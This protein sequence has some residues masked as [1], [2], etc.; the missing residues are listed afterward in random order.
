[1]SA[2]TT[3]HVT[4]ATPT[5]TEASPSVPKRQRAGSIINDFCLTTSIQGFPGIARSES[6]HNRLFWTVALISFTGIML[7]FIVDAI[8]VYFNYPTQTSVTIVTEWPQAFPAVSICNY[9]MLRYDRFIGPFL[10]YTN[11][12][13]ITNTTDTT[14]FTGT[15]SY[16]I[17]DFLIDVVNK[18]EPF[19]DY[20]FPLSGMMMSCSY[21]GVACT[22]ANFTS[23]ISPTYGMC[24]TFNAKLKNID[25]GGI[26]YN[27]D[28][29]ANGL[30]QLALYTHEQQYVP[31]MTQGTGIVALVHDNS[32][33][34][35]VE[36]EAVF[37]S[38]GRHHRLGFKK[39]KSLF[40][41]SPYTTCT[42]TISPG[43]QIVYDAYNATD[44]AYSQYYCFNA[45]IQ[46]YIYSHCGCGGPSLWNVP[47]VIIHGT[48]QRINISLC[49]TSNSCPKQYITFILNTA[50]TL[51]AYC[52]QC[53]EECTYTEF[54]MKLSSLLAP[55]VTA[56][57][58]IK[59][60]VESSNITLSNDWSTSWISEIQ[61][62]YVSLEVAYETVRT[63]VY[64]QQARLSPVDVLSNV[65]GQTGLWIGISFLSVIEIA[66]MAYRL[67]RCLWHNLRT[68]VNNR[69]KTQEAIQ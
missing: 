9:G 6:I 66:E 23:F 47:A 38:P 59:Q 43:L 68:I 33:V 61:S 8:S 35:N 52:S 1:M 12:L 51:N 56:L 55:P 36:M 37:L 50:S 62:N 48:D 45:C 13:N 11:A 57:T 64:S 42:E 41:A 65:G 20:F 10:N 14:N 46:E 44:Y 2:T 18:G 31:F 27:S 16:Y 32:E 3:K 15:Q 28:N 24:N 17:R 54:I 25:N 58:D 7:Y 39:K 63:E 29:G 49:N 26:R 67:M 40:L 60:F 53:T 19:N 4:V 30:L 21:N 34:P 5:D 69:I 22:A